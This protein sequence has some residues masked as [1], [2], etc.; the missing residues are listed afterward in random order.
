MLYIPTYL[1]QNNFLKI[2]TVPVKCAIRTRI[3]AVDFIVIWF[4]ALLTLQNLT[5]QVEN[6][7]LFAYGCISYIMKD[8]KEILQ[9]NQTFQLPPSSEIKG[10]K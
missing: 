6:H 5:E 3:I 2:L 10:D 9:T 4:T 8:A 7:S 1:I